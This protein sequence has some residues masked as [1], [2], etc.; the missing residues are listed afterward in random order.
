MPA[1]FDFPGELID[2]LKSSQK[3]VALTGAGISAESGVPTFRDAQTGLWAQYD[4]LQLATPESFQSNPRLVWDWYTWRRELISKSSPN[5]GHYALVKLESFFPEFLL[6]TQ[7]V[8]GH[9]QT[10]GSQRVIELHG[11]I[12]R[13]KCS[14]DG[15]VIPEGVKTTGTPPRCPDCGSYLR[16]DV[17]WFGENLPKNALETAIE[18]ARTCDAFLSVGTSSRVEPAA[19]L[20]FIAF[21]CGSTVIEINLQDTPL[22][23]KATYSIR[24][25]AGDALPSITKEVTKG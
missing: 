15:R 25:T 6:V 23:S 11:N 5:P 24:C 4:P 19:S 16:P 2:N 9:H 1:E 22:T 8:D 20:P 3:V 7:N 14:Q 10:A 12:F 18:A 17:V 13:T 21:E